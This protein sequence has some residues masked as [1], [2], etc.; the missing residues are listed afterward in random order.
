MPKASVVRYR[1]VS[2]HLE[3]EHEHDAFGLLLWSCCLGRLAEACRRPAQ[4]A[5]RQRII[6]WCD[7]TGGAAAAFDFTTKAVLQEAVASKEYWRLRDPHGRPAGT[8]L[9]SIGKACRP[10]I[11]LVQQLC[12]RQ[13]TAEVFHKDAICLRAMLGRAI[14]FACH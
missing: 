9:L 1:V 8:S 13:H 10:S 11:W 3:R 5:H 4:D 14:G 7:A 12:S 2:C 6:D